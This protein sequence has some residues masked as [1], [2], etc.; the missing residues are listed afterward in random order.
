[1][2]L[3]F[4]RI[5][6]D[7]YAEITGSQAYPNIKG[8]AYFYETFNGTYVVATV[9][10]LEDDG[11]HGFH[12]HEGGSCTGTEEDPFRD[13]RGHFN[14]WNQNHPNHVGDLPPLLA[15]Q[16][17]AFSSFYTNRFY[18]AEV[19]GKTIIIHEM[20]DDFRSQPSGNAGKMI[21]C[22]V[23]EEYQM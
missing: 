14:P 8:N 9:T 10:G 15:N 7:A 20:A 6:P 2:M 22:G 19:L 13:A 5:Q 21:A 12:I 1:M 4:G 18:P 23:I 3:S 17:F 11:Y 16:G